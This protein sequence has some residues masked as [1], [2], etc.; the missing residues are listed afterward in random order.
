MAWLGIYLESEVNIFFLSIHVLSFKVF[1]IFVF[2]SE[3]KPPLGASGETLVATLK[4]NSEHIQLS[5]K[6]T[7]K[8]PIT[9]AD[10][11]TND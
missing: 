6:T 11:K 5:K 1:G 10:Y 7:E 2:V 4:K 9:R 3:R 8:R